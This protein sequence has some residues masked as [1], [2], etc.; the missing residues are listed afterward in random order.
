MVIVT[1]LFMLIVSRNRWSCNRY[2]ASLLRKLG[3]G[4]ISI[5][6]PGWVLCIGLGLTPKKGLKGYLLRCIG[7]LV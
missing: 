3:T 5:S 6:Y 1:Y 2:A 7:S 4:F